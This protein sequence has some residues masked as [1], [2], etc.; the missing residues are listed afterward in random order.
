MDNC[1][2][3]FI[4]QIDAGNLYELLIPRKEYG[5][6]IFK[7]YKQLKNKNTEFFSEDDIIESIIEH[8]NQDKKPKEYAKDIIRELSEFFLKETNNQFRLTQYAKGF[9][10]T[11]LEK[12]E[13]DLEPSKIEKKLL[14]LKNTISEYKSFD[15]W[16]DLIFTN[17]LTGFIESQLESLERQVIN[18]IKKFR[19]G[20]NEEL[21]NGD[22]LVKK[23][24]DN[25][26]EIN[27]QTN[28]IKGSLNHA[29]AIKSI[30]NKIDPSEEL[31]PEQSLQKQ[32]SVI[33]FLDN[34]ISDFERISKRIE[35]VIPKLR[36]F[37]GNM[38]RLD[39]EKNTN[40]LLNLLLVQSKIVGH[41]P[42]W[43]LKFPT[44]KNFCLDRSFPSL[45]NKFY[46]VDNKKNLNDYK[47]D[48]REMYM[49][50]PSIKVQE[51][52]R[53][54]TKRTIEKRSKLFRFL[55][56]IEQ[57][58]ECKK[59]IDFKLYF[60]RIIKDTNDINIAVKISSILIKKYSKSKYYVFEIKRP[61]SKYSENK[62][63]WDM[64]V[65]KLS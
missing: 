11:I 45:S 32:K 64:K 53:S 25:I 27:K 62:I 9:C 1:K 49:P 3:D 33:S 16:F 50:K 42:N 44:S 19:A 43:K 6:V 54:S 20:V 2:V 34:L 48:K 26:E 21:I 55:D 47:A 60:D 35:R 31:N 14:F 65:T 8:K 41:K 17:D 57:E 58:L 52:Q 10:Q 29:E 12:I 56:E 7:L 37:Y 36:Q 18:V 5:I 40:K 61:F 24:L 28:K 13:E 30:I 51:S 39:F 38:T 46:F 63:I 23:I 59:Y 15:D 4:T 22:V